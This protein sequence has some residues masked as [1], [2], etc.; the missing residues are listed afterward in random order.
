[1]TQ[2]HKK[3]LA[4]SPDRELASFRHAVMTDA[5][6]DVVSVHSESAACFEI[7]FGRCGVL[8]LCHKLAHSARES[9]ACDFEKRCPDPYIIAILENANDRFPKQAHKVLIHSPDL[10]TLVDALQEKMAA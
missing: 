1:M 3:V 9:L 6:F 2:R 10:S 5:G 8:L 7:H 4:V